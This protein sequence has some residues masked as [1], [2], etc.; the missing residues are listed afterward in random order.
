MTAPTAKLRKSIY[1]RDGHACMD[2]G[3]NYQLTF[4]H[5]EASGHGGRGRKAPPLTAAEGITLC[6]R[7][8]EACE[9]EGQTRAF[10]LGYKTRRNRGNFPAHRIPVY[11]R[12]TRFWW[13]LDEDGG[14]EAI[15]PAFAA[16]LLGAAG[17][18][19]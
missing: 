12:S 1:A 13:L 10:M 2:C 16:E 3:T 8:N 19:P 9:A 4:Q 5:R 14:R 7:C 18:I 11:E 15:Q 6:L 17:S